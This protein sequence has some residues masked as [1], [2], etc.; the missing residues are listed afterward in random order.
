M[1]VFKDNKAHSNEWQGFALYDYEQFLTFR[2]LE[3]RPSFENVQ[4]FRNRNHGIFGQNL[5][6]AQFL[7]GIVA[8][9]QW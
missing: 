6:A 4:S 3:K 8:D 5:I 2:E 9:N 1:K 7:G